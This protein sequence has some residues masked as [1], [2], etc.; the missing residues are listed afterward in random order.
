MV[1]SPVLQLVHGWSPLAA[2][3]RA[4]PFAFAMGAVSPLSSILAKRLGMRVIIPAGMA[5]MGLGCSTCRRQAWTRRPG[6]TRA[7]PNTSRQ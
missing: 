2:G 5:L 7:S 4:L 3:L 1:S 6:R